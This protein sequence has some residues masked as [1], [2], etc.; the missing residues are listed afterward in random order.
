MNFIRRLWSRAVREIGATKAEPVRLTPLPPE[1]GGGFLERVEISELPIVRIFGW[2]VRARLPD[3]KLSTRAR[4]SV[5]PVAIA[6]MFRMD[7]CRTQEDAGPFCGFRMDYLL[8][9]HEIPEAILVGEEAFLPLIAPGNCASVEPHYAHLFN[10]S[11]VRSREHIYGSGPPTSVADEFKVFAEAATGKVLDFGAGSGDLATHLSRRGLDVV[12]LEL[13]EPRI[14]NALTQEAMA[15]V[16]LY[17][18]DLPLPFASETF[19]W[20]VSTEVLEHLHDPQRFIPE[21]ARVLKPGGKMLLTT[22]DISSIPSSFLTGTVPWHLLEATHFNFFT[23]ASLLSLYA[24]YFDLVDF[25]SLGDNKVNGF[26]V[27]GS[28]GAIFVR[29]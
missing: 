15:L 1:S 13:D 21:F 28:I 11:R 23:P 29:R 10:E 17:P 6:R 5:S 9:P 20:I 25:Y 22:P 16:K 8:E 4:G 26:Y 3:F 18:G 24:P 27:P 2:Q 12:G 14:R 7:V 19:D